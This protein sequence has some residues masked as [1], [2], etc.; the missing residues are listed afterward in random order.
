MSDPFAKPVVPETGLTRSLA[1]W[2]R[3]S[4]EALAAILVASLALTITGLAAPVLTG[5]FI[6][7]C[8]A[9]GRTE[10]VVPLL[11][12]LALTAV[13]RAVLFWTQQHLL[14]R[15][16]TRLA[17]ESSYRFFR[18][19][20]GLPVT[21]FA[22]RSRGE[23]GSR[24]G[25]N[26]RVARLVARTLTENALNVI[27]AAL[28]LAV[29]AVIDVRLALLGAGI[30]ALNFFVLWRVSRWRKALNRLMLEERARLTAVAFGGLQAIETVK[31]T[32]SESDFFS[33]WAG[34]LARALGVGQ[35][36]DTSSLL[37]SAVPVLLSSLSTAV[38]LGVGAIRVMDE[39][40]TVGMLVAFQSLM[41]S[42]L[43]PIDQF[44]TL[45]KTLQEVEGELRR[46]AEVTDHR[47]DPELAAAPARAGWNGPPRL[48]GRVEVR[49]VTFGYDP[50]GPPL[51][52]NFSLTVHPGARV[53]L[54]GASGSGK[55]TV[56]RLVCGVYQ[57]WGGGVRF[58]GLPRGQIPRAVLADSLA[59]V[60]QEFFLFEGTV[61][62]VL[63]MWDATVVE[64]DIV[65]AAKD[66]CIHQEI[67]ARPG[68]Y[69]SRVEEGG[70]NFSGGQRQRLEIARALVRN[71]AVLVLDEATSALDAATEGKVDENLRRRGCTCLIVAHRLSTIRDCDE[72]VV[73][74]RGRIVQRGTH[75][76]LASDT[77][78]LYYR[79]IRS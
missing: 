73:L 16:E 47:P 22:G 17:L 76:R 5:V 35:R 68:A 13:V 4:G 29:M 21:F 40:L 19:V 58:D 71:P 20:L 49:N 42:F 55:S 56:A 1:G 51:L 59:V 53:A 31:A 10:W 26:D 37:V 79:L 3:G 74:D 57:P 52:V 48:A 28:Y 6:D 64:E 61:R 65:R 70:A 18:H 15:F 27:T 39:K 60:D 46:L 30:A 36:M 38:I 33:R 50:G 9:A 11:A 25:I 44:V 69:G 41:L 14:L 63:T 67:A 45:G 34:V 24:M 62:D 75:D 23:I 32:G 66:A 7:H 54:V 43:A 2:L 72:I 77:A 78:G 12:G 8:L